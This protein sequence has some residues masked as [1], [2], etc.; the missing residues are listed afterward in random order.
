MLKPDDHALLHRCHKVTIDISIDAF[1]GLN[2]IVRE[3]SH[4]EKI[5]MFIASF[6][7]RNPS[8]IHPKS[9]QNPLKIHKFRSKIV[10]KIDTGSQTGS[11]TVPNTIFSIF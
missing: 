4:W 1:G 7:T 11:K 2:S 3:G 5:D 6:Y 9:S 8:K 10:S